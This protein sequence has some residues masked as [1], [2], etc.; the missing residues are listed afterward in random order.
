[1]HDLWSQ[2]ENEQTQENSSSQNDAAIPTVESDLAAKPAITSRLRR[3]S[4]RM[5]IAQLRTWLLHSYVPSY[6]RALG[7][8]RIYR[9]CYWLDALGTDKKQVLLPK[10]VQI[11]QSTQPGKKARANGRSNGKNK[12]AL[13]ANLPPI[14]QPLAA[15]ARQ[16]RQEKQPLNLQAVMLEAGSSRT[17]TPHTLTLEPLNADGQGEIVHASWL[18][19][20]PTLLPQIDQSPA[21]FL[22]NPF[23]PLLFSS[24]TL[25]AIT[26]RTAP[27][28]L[29]LLVSHKQL[30]SHLAAARRNTQQGQILTALLKSDRW[31]ALLPPPNEPEK[32][33]NLNGA[34]DLLIKSIQRGFLTVQPINFQVQASPA[35][36]GHSPYTLLFA[37]RRQ[38]SLASM[39]DAVCLYQRESVELGRQ[40]VLGESWFAEREQQRRTQERQQLCQRISS[41]GKAQR[42]RRWSDLR[43]YFL[44][45]NFGQ[46]T[47]EEYDSIIL[48]L[49][50]EGV[51]KVQR[52]RIQTEESNPDV[53][54]I[55]DTLIWR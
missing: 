26:Q 55:E 40:G 41:Q 50:S 14:L 23:G 32:E 3:P 53:P 10:N 5:I 39:N 47:V 48:E 16:L 46:F 6:G 49:E 45:H 4:E 36:A 51:I 38:D 25:A 2:L 54:G 7:S 34:I 27:T 1:M 24:E 9:R 37:T 43:H 21:I 28:E 42:I 13:E 20:A 11:E 35:A 22:L 44:L 17:K 29:L 8:T 31:K 19:A 52:R 33:P 30:A 18:E 15:I 12:N